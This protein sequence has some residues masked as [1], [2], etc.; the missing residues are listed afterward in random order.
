MGYQPLAHFPLEKFTED[1]GKH[2]NKIQNRHNSLFV[3]HQPGFR[4]GGAT[5]RT[6]D[7]GNVLIPKLQVIAIFQ[8]PP[9]L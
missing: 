2:I 3:S 1:E 6:E 5:D 9:Q 4:I 7:V 8:A